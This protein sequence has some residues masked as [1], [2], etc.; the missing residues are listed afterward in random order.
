MHA[1]VTVVAHLKVMELGEGIMASC[2]LVR[3]SGMIKD[4]T[5]NTQEC[6]R[7]FRSVFFSLFHQGCGGV[8]A[9]SPLFQGG[10]GVT[11]AE[12]SYPMGEGQGTTWMSRQL[13]AGPLLM[14]E[15]A[16]WGTNCTSGA[17][18]GLSI[19]LKDTL[20]CSSVKRQFWF[21]LLLLT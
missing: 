3:K 1:A 13:I 4:A 17:I 7:Q 2:V 5:Q 10:C 9:L 8:T 14:A 21:I 15:A 16:T 6:R 19:L 20:T 12:S 18:W 11:W